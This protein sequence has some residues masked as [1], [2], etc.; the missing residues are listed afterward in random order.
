MCNLLLDNH[1][2]EVPNA[3]PKLTNVRAADLRSGIRSRFGRAGW[4]SVSAGGHHFCG[5][6]RRIVGT[7]HR[8]HHAV[9][10]S[11]YL[12]RPVSHGRFDHFL[13]VSFSTFAMTLSDLTQ[14]V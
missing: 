7:V 8:G 11:G 6:V 5:A 9:S 2:N 14:V 10:S 1:G 13:F 3:P 12:V 4:H